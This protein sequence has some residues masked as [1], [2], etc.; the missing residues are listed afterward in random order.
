MADFLRQFAERFAG[1]DASNLDRLRE[2]YSDDIL[3]R[4]PLHEVRGLP[5]V[6]G[7]FGE[8]YANV[9]ELRFDF[10]GFDQSAEGEGYLRW[11]MSYRHPRL[12]GGALIRVEG[13]SHLRWRDKVYQHRDYFDAGALLYE[14]LPILGRVI[15]WLKGRLA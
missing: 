14:H 10:Y 13:C 7:Y 6:R 1:L 4:D 3:F 5:A 11:T 2:L 15:A 12:R 8:L 9:S